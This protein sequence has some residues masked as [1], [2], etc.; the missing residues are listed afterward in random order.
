MSGCECDCYNWDDDTEPHFLL[1]ILIYFII[2]LFVS[3]I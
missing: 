2:Y 1:T 3:Y